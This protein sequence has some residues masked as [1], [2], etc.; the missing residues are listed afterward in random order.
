MTNFVARTCTEVV[1][2]EL[3][4]G[5]EN[6]SLSLEKFRGTDTYV[7]L[8]APGAGK[9]TAFQR[10]VESQAGCYVT[11]RDFR[12]FDDRPEWHGTTLYID[13][14][15]ETRVGS[16]DGRTPFDE[17]RAKLDR[18]GRPRLRLSCREA[19][20]FGDNDRDNLK[21]VSRDG[22]VAVLRLDPL[23]V[24]DIREILRANFGIGDPDRFIASA[25]GRGI[26]ALLP[27]PQS[28]QMLVLAVKGNESWPETRMQTF[29]MA[30]RKLILEHN[31]EHRIAIPDNV[32][33]SS[34]MGAAGRLCAIQL[35]TG[36]DGY[37]LTGYE[38]NQYFLGL[39][40]ISEKKRTMFDRVLR[41]KL[42]E[43]P[44]NGQATPVHRQIAE[45]LAGNYLHALIDNGL[46]VGRILSL[47]TGHDGMIVSE[48]RGLSAWLAA[49]NKSSRA[50]IIARDPLGAVIYGDTRHF[51]VQE[52][53]LVL[54][55][56][57]RQ[58]KGDRQSL[59][60]VRMDAR[61]EDLATPDMAGRVSCDSDGSFAR[62]EPSNRCIQPAISPQ[63]R[64]GI[65]GNC[66]S[67]AVYPQGQELVS[68][69]KKNRPPGVP[70]KRKKDT[71]CNHGA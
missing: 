5:P 62:R 48:L 8:G 11:A 33:I 34:L 59:Q 15:D 7:L 53:S 51:S 30:C 31:R 14:L 28:L 63:A 12:T 40:Q 61:L 21:A 37:A 41:T 58:A 50:E 42:F 39:E 64:A 70:E 22:R 65:P 67:H 35:L 23:S 38:S 9:T 10:E 52:K 6:R 27:N 71:A 68:G 18:L 57:Q 20:W 36:Y 16:A 17:I 32:D 19:D 13:G 1:E 66:R 24:D 3:R 49:F 46:P 54:E 25:R 2:G 56:L 4:G 55:G 69:S 44:A 43:S 26:D 29:D 60:T 47:M 45:F